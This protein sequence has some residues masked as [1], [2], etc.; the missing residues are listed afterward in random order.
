MLNTLSK[1][2]GE[3]PR[4]K[5]WGKQI[6]QA[7]SLQLLVM[8]LNALA[9]F[10]IL[11]I[12]DKEDYA[13]FS[14]FYATVSMVHV[15]SNSN[16]SSGF[17]AIGGKIWE[18]R[19]AF[20]SLIYTANVLRQKI[21]FVVLPI[22][23]GYG[24]FLLWKQDLYT[25]HWWQL[26]VIG[27]LIGL[28]ALPGIYNLFYRHALLLWKRTIPYYTAEVVQT[29]TRLIPIIILWYFG[30]QWNNLLLLIIATIIGSFL[31]L[32]VIILSSESFYD[33]SAKELNKAHYDKLIYYPK[34]TWHNTL[35]FTF[36]GQIGL[37]LLSI[38]GSTSSVAEFGALS[39]FALLNTLFL[40]V[41]NVIF[42][43]FF[44]KKNSK[45]ALA[46][47]YAFGIIL[48]I[49]ALV[50]LVLFAWLLPQVFI[51]LVGNDYTSIK[52]VLILS[53]LQNGLIIIG[54]LLF[55]MNSAK[56]W[57]KFS[58]LFGIPS[59]I[60]P[61]GI[62]AF[63]FDLSTLPGVLL[64]AVLMELGKILLQLFNGWHGLK[65]LERVQIF[66]I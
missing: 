5:I 51:F 66:E 38:L 46:R 6:G 19:A 24:L 9:G 18:D 42:Y 22:V 17:M 32:R 63:F 48:G 59:Y 28:N 13:A 21:A 54:G 33:S 58:P 8:V 55:G 36:Q 53:M 34:V 47:N 27:S 15:L 37:I 4:F 52:E 35:F 60:I 11:R 3:N 50:F 61:I 39:R 45:E 20:S 64:L 7:T 14:I 23:I 25:N 49:L 26:L 2:I 56:G 62:G 12:L 30:I 57:I 40:S 43:P 1:K 16:L 65:S 41:A 29:L 31:G 44:A 10:L